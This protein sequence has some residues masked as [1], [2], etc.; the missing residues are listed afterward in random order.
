[1]N[2]H[3]YMA[4]LKSALGIGSDYALAQQLNVTQPAVSRWRQNKS[5]IGD[6]LAPRVAE[7]LGLS[8]AKVLADLHAEREKNEALRSVWLSI[9]AQFAKAAC[10]SS[11]ALAFNICTFPGTSEAKA[12]CFFN[13]NDAEYKFPNNSTSKKHSLNAAT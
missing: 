9:S 13:H 4:A 11:V 6:D 8:P 2:T 3:D 10:I 12:P 7:I 1:M 5:T